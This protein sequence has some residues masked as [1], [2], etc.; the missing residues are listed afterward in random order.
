MA[1][2]KQEIPSSSAGME[3]RDS[4]HEQAPSTFTLHIISPSVGVNS[5]IIFNEMSLGTTIKELK[6]KIRQYLSTTQSSMIDAEDQLEDDAQRL[7]HRG[8]MLKQS[9]DT[10]LDVFG[11]GAV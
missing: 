2:I 3:A 8:R 7:I 4:N 10:M 5:P 6:N 9:E 11:S 1:S